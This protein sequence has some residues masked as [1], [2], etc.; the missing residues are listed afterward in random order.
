M[1]ACAFAMRMCGPTLGFGLSYLMLRIYIDPTKTPTITHSDPRWLGAWWL[2]WIILGSVLL[3]L[4]ALISLFPKQLKNRKRT[5][6]YEIGDENCIQ[7]AK[8]DNIE[9]N[10]A[11]LKS[12]S[13][14]KQNSIQVYKKC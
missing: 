10:D 1:L 3:I 11:Q 8:N 12:K 13:S 4:A 5:V 6:E 2:G 9:I 7:N 14:V